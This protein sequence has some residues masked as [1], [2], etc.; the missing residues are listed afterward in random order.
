M[1]SLEE[2]VKVSLNTSTET[3]TLNRTISDALLVPQ[4]ITASLEVLINKTLT[5]NTS[6]LN[7]TNLSQKTL[8]LVLAELPFPLSFT[9]IA[10]GH[11]P[12]VIVSATEDNSDCIIKTSIKT[13]KQLKAKASLTQLIKEDQL[14]VEGDLNIAQQ[15]ANTAQSLA[16]DWQTELAKHLGDIPTHNLL[17]FGN[18]VT[19]KIT[20]TIKQAETDINE[21]VVH[22]KRLVVTSSQIKAFNQEVTT[23]A[24]KLDSLSK[25]VDILL[26]RVTTL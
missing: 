13:L 19:K 20:S 23:V 26:A 12:E 2:Q 16:I 21:Y 7:V 4:A 25:R 5:L 9:V 24:T 11:L 22:E 18:K 8:T 3:S 1:S 10:H 6:P 14:N 17:H 15:F